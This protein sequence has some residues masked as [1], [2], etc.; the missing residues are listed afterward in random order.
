MSVVSIYGDIVDE[1]GADKEIVAMAEELLEQ[2]KNNN[3]I[4]LATVCAFRDKSIHT[5]IRD[6]GGAMHLVI[7]GVTVLQH[8]IVVMAMEGYSQSK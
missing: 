6:G 1:N 3:L 2:A 8:E 5:R 7:A 4:G